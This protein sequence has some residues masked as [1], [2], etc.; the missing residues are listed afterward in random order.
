MAVNIYRILGNLLAFLLCLVLALWFA[1]YNPL[2]AILFLVAA[3]DNYEDVY[4]SLTHKYLIP[5]EF[6]II[7]ILVEIF[8]LLFGTFLFVFGI[9]YYLYFQTPFVCLFLLSGAFIMYS[10]IR[11]INKDIHRLGVAYG[12]GVYTIER[13]EFEFIRKKK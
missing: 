8:M 6:L 10:S 3:F 13:E 7:D 2:I 5:K 1:K 12:L 9:I 11:D 4:E